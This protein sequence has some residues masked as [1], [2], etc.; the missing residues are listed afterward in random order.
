MEHYDPD[1]D[2]DDHVQRVGWNVSLF[3]IGSEVRRIEIRAKRMLFSHLFI[4]IR[5]ERMIYFDFH[6]DCKLY[7]RFAFFSFSILYIYFLTLN[8]MWWKGSASEWHFIRRD[9]V[10][11]QSLSIPFIHL[12][13]ISRQNSFVFLFL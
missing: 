1:Q 6:S 5:A 13:F 10:R 2:G 7:Q 9:A 4:E 3:I 12:C 11:K 8:W